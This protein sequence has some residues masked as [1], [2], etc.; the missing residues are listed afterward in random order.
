MFSKFVFMAAG[1]TAELTV[2][3]T[4]DDEGDSPT[5]VSSVKSPRQ[6]ETERRELLHRVSDA[7]VVPP[8]RPGVGKAPLRPAAM[9]PPTA[10]RS[11]PNNLASAVYVLVKGDWPRSRS[12]KLVNTRVLGTYSSQAL[13]EAAKAAYLQRGDWEEGYGYH[14]GEDAE[15]RIDIY[16]S[17][18]DAPAR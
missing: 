13:A 18:L 15:S 3:L 9:A 7:H 1:S 6:R 8:P 11:K 5:F 2:D 4:G 12:A 16:R 10:K 14:Q 17:V